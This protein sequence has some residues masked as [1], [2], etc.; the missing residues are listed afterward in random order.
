MRETIERTSLANV[1]LSKLEDKMISGFIDNYESFR[2][3]KIVDNSTLPSHLIVDIL[4]E[5]I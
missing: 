2:T 3:H 1:I 5:L 4:L